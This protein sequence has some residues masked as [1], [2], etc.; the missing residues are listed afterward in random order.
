[1]PIVKIQCGT[2]TG[3]QLAT[4]VNQTIDLA[5]ANTE[6]INTLSARPTSTP[7]DFAKVFDNADNIDELFDTTTGESAGDIVASLRKTSSFIEEVAPPTGFSV[8]ALFS[9]VLAQKVEVLSLVA[10]PVLT[11]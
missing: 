2:T 3:S 1:M 10:Y 9:S 8:P 6:D 4:R 7:E 11:L 5:E